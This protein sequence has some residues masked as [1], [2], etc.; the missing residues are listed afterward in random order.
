MSFPVACTDCGAK[1]NMPARL[2]NERVAGRVLVIHCRKCKAPITLD[3]RA[4]SE[5][6]ETTS[7]PKLVTVCCSIKSEV[8]T[9]I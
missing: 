2:W 1:F 3:G 8:A 9:V 4:A 5:S 7:A 6:A